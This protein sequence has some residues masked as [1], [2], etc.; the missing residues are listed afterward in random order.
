[1]SVE[2][3]LPEGWVECSVESLAKFIDY[4]G[5]TPKKTADGIPLITAKNIR[6]GFISREPREFIADADYDDWMT[7]GIPNVGDVVITTEAPMG[8][9]ALIDIEEKFALAQRA[10]CLQTYEAGLGRYLHYALRSPIFQKLLTE[11]ATGTTVSGIK[12]ATL[13]KLEIPLPPL[14]EQQVIAD[15]LDTLLAQVE[16]TKTR[17]ERIPDVLKRFR[18]SVLAA[19]VSG[20]LTEGWRTINVTENVLSAIEKRN[21]SKQGN[22]KLRG[23]NSWNDINLYE[24]PENWAWIENHNLA[25]DSSNAICAGPFGTIFKAKDFRDEG[26]PIIFLRHVKEE[27]FNQNKPNYMDENVW[28]D[29]HQEYTIHGGELLITKLGDPPGECCEY[30][31]GNGAAMVT[32]DV[33]KMA[34][35]E[36]VADKT[37]LKHF[38]NSPESKRLVSDAAFGA[39]RLRIDI[40]LFKRFP[41]PLPPIPE[42]QEIVRRVEQLFA[43][44]DSIERQVEA[45]QQWVS[46][47]TQSILAKAFR[48]ELTADWRAA[49]PELISGENSAEALLARIKQERESQAPKKRGSGKT[50]GRKEKAEA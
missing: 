17:L 41:I 6:D 27:G 38:F 1:M 12:S 22:L 48:G 42:Q 45:A 11:N 40:S 28:A 50:G 26:I 5:R 35:D 2:N 47:L 49:N 13:K 3:K 30:P 31:E 33:L 14:A 23:K 34:V 18:Q 9:V 39:T 46:Q 44:A 36:V 37:Y 29:L 4:R 8:N 16:A 15:Q 19:A 25:C 20:K 7:R 32:P 24:L 10:I 43:Y 21:K